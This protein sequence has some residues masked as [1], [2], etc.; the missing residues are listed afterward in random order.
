[1]PRSSVSRLRSCL[2]RTLPTTTGSTISRCAGLT[3]S[4]RC[5]FLPSSSRSRRVAEV[6]LHVARAFDIVGGGRAALELVKQRAV[7]LRHHLRQHIEAAAMRHAKH[8]LLHAEIAAALDDLLQRRDQQLSPVETET[9]GAGEL[10]VAN[11]SKP[12]ASTNLLRIAR[13]PSRVNVI[14]LSAPSMRVLHPLFC[15]ASDMHEFDADRPAGG[16]AHRIATISRNVA[17]SSRTR[18][19]GRSCGRGRLR[20]NHRSGDRARHACRAA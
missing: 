6:V 10:D 2:A 17:I 13:L 1:M 19:R 16:L 9:L 14:S 15:S 5:T 8:D 4:E 11:F 7:R 18:C 20:R 12:S 3:V